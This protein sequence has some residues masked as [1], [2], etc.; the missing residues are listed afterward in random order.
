M[1][2]KIKFTDKPGA[3]KVIYGVIIAILC[4]T[5]I[6]VGIVA[7]NNRKTPTP[8]PGGTTGD[9]TPDGTTPDEGVKPDEKPDETPNEKPGNQ[10]MS[11]ISPVVG[12]VSKE[13]SLTVPVYSETLEEWRVHPGID[14]SCVEG[15]DV[16]CV[17]DG[18]VADVYS[19]PL[20][21]FT[22]VVDHGNEVKSIYSNLDAA[23][24]ATPKKGDAVKLGDKIGNVGDGALF[25]LA[26]E[27]HLH[28]EVEVNSVASDPLEYIS[29]EAKKASLGIETEESEAS[30]QLL[31]EKRIKP[32]GK[33][34]RRTF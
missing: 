16:Y 10:K 24:D 14:I 30:R 19:D 32:D 25:E 29:D 21:G 12:T 27:A 1:E 4:I 13:H 18:V 15:A 33:K 6:V 31:K 34:G 9:T 17:F 23:S 8:I 3:A 26:E 7:A 5:A 11:F 20:Y 2:K 22:V 28:F